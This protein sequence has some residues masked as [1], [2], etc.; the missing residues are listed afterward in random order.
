MMRYGGIDMNKTYIVRLTDA[1]RHELV[2]L[3]KSGKAAT[4][5]RLSGNPPVTSCLYQAAFLR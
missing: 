3:T 5:Q 1:E 4:S 2:Q